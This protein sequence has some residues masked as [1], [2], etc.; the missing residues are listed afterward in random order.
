MYI[1][2]YYAMPVA[3]SPNRNKHV[4]IN[5]SDLEVRFAVENH[6]YVACR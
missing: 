4:Y 3:T 5:Q 6:I 1:L 2:E